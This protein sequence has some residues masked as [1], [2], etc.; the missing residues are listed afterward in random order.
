MSNI[1]AINITMMA[2][3][4]YNRN[5]SFEVSETKVVDTSAIPTAMVIKPSILLALASTARIL[6]LK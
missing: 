3:P 4:I 5:E 2:S 1:N 6:L